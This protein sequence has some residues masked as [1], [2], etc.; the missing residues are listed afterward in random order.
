[1]SISA[2][3]VAPELGAHFHFDP[4]IGKLT[5]IKNFLPNCCLNRMRRFNDNDQVYV[6]H[7]GQL[8]RFK[9]KVN[10]PEDSHVKSYHR[11]EVIVK[12]SFSGLNGDYKEQIFQRI[13]EKAEINLDTERRLRRTLTYNKIRRIERAVNQVSKEHQ[14]PV[15]PI[16]PR[17]LRDERGRRIV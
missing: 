17:L 5:L 1:M 6:N 15:S 13:Q 14:A 10:M 2:I 11:I 3:N 7:N 16:S 8:E 4:H 12:E 9:R